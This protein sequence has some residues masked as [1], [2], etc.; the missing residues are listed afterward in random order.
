VLL[1]GSSNA[2]DHW[3]PFLYQQYVLVILPV[4]LV[5]AKF[6]ENE[7]GIAGFRYRNRQWRI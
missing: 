1:E 2:A 6:N 3:Q 4:D 7:V 5:R